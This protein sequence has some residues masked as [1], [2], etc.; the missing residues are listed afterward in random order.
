MYKINK[1]KYPFYL[2]LKV[3][4][5]NDLLDFDLSKYKKACLASGTSTPISSIEEIDKYLKEI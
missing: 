1:E 3:E 5:K 4:K 2:V